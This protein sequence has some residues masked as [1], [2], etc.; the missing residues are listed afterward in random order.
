MKCE[1]CK[2]KIKEDWR[3]SLASFLVVGDFC[4]SCFYD[5]FV[6]TEPRTGDE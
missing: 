5:L 2:K 3:R 6:Y 4:K 1:E